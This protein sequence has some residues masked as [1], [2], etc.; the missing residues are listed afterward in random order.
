MRIRTITLAMAL[1]ALL[2]LPVK[3]AF[4]DPALQQNSD[5]LKK[6][7][8]E[9]YQ[10]LLSIPSSTNPGI[11][12]T[13][14]HCMVGQR[15]SVWFLLEGFPGTFTRSCSIPEGVSLFFETIA[16]SVW[17]SPNVC[18]QG[19]ENLS[20]KD[21]RAIAKPFIDSAT[22]QSVEVDGNPVKKLTRVQSDVYALAEPADNVILPSCG[23]DQ[24]A[25]IY[26]PVITDGYFVLL[27][28]LPVGNHTL[29]FKQRFRALLAWT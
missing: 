27:K 7:S 25:G 16:A 29:H 2:L 1:V 14:E 24:P 19:P 17:N 4:A 5:E 20:V 21:L 6:L 18:G 12:T 8:A 13:G 23:G 15:G 28:P 11:D 10:W 9:I 22:G 26:A 3:L